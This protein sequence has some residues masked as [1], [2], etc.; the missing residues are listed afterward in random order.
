LLHYV[1][2]ISRLGGRVTNCSGAA[3]ATFGDGAA[4]ASEDERSE[5]SDAAV[6]RDY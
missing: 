1:G 6:I 2:R 3:V 5:P 4:K